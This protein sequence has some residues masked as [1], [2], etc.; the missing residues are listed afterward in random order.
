[1]SLKFLQV[2][3]SGGRRP[4]QNARLLILLKSWVIFIW[5]EVQVPVAIPVARPL[6]A[7]VQLRGKYGK[8][9][10]H[11]RFFAFNLGLC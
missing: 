10:N 2:S 11:C 9:N 7:L 4:V 1:M 3:A 5:G 6:A 8:K